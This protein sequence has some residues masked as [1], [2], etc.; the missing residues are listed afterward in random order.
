MH[1]QSEA[2]YQ[3]RQYAKANHCNSKTDVRQKTA[4]KD[5]AK[6][7]VAVTDSSRGRCGDD[8]DLAYV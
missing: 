8:Q 6:A 5:Q 1:E 2:Q 3:Y 4:P 7:N